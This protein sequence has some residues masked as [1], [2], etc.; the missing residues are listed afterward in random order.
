[1]TISKTNC[2]ETSLNR[3]KGDNGLDKWMPSNKE[4][5]CQYVTD[6]EAIKR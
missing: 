1:M 3:S 6:W 5:H 2:V 4:Y